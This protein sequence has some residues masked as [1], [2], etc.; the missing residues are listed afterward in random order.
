MRLREVVD[1]ADALA[2]ADAEHTTGA[3]ADHRLHGLEARTLRVLPRIQEAE[4]ARASVRLEPDRDEAERDDDPARES[5]RG[6]RRARDQQDGGEDDDDRD[7]GSEVGLGDHEDAE[8]EQQDPDRPP[9]MRERSRRRSFGEIRRRPHCECELR[10]L[11]GLERRRPDFDPASRA[12][13]ARSD[14]EHREAEEE[15]GENE[16]RSEEPKP[17]VVE[18]SGRH[19]QEDTDERVRALLLQV[20]HR[21][22]ARERCRRG[23]RA[24]DHHEPERDKAE[25]HE[26]EQPALE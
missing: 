8:A 26:H 3:E 20:R 22:G 9:E 24:V 21:I 10:E 6:H 11:G 5:E 19:H 25:R 18:A 14:H 1:L 15:R 12:V 4:K 2:E 7:R 13:H 23:G 16:G 17:T